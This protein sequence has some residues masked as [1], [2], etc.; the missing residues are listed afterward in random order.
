MLIVLGGILPLG[1]V[2]GISFYVVRGQTEERLIYALNQGYT[3]VYQAVGDKLSRLHNISTLFAVNDMTSPVLRFDDREMDVAEQL[4]LFENI[5]SYAYGLEM[6]LDSSN[7]IFF[8]EDDYLVVNTQSNR[9]HPLTDAYGSQWYRSLREN[10]G[11]PVWVLLDGS[12]KSGSYAAIARELWNPDDYSQTVGILAIMMEQK[13]LDNMLQNS[14][15]Q[16]ALYLETAD[17]TLL[18]SNL[19]EEE[20]SRLS[21][22]ERNVDDREFR[23]ILLDGGSCYAR[24]CRIDGSNVYLVSVI[25]KEAVRRSINVLNGNMGLMFVGVCLLMLVVMGIRMAV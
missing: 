8:I 5:N 11:R 7:I 25:P 17:G 1:I 19:P 20:L 12:G 22:S 21:I 15:E 4:M 24:S 14:H 23:S 9:Y 13:N 3:R 16:Q 6:T 10:N 18:A 2:M